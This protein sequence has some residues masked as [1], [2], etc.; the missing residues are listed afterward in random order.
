MTFHTERPH[1]ISVQSLPSLPSVISVISVITDRHPL[2]S[3]TIKVLSI[4]P[5]LLSNLFNINPSIVIPFK[6]PFTF[7]AHF[8]PSSTSTPERVVVILSVVNH[9]VLQTHTYHLHKY[10][11]ISVSYT[12]T[13]PRHINSPHYRDL[14]NPSPPN[15]WVT[16]CLSLNGAP[17]YQK[18]ITCLYILPSLQSI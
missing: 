6:S 9:S 14:K 11:Y 17:V 4:T 7:S 2:Q 1:G 5:Q 13:L 10:I 12:P 15:G 3:T 8:D 18:R 16:I